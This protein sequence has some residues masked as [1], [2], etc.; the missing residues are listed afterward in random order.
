MRAS[1]L[2]RLP[3]LLFHELRTNRHAR[4]AV[5]TVAAVSALGVLSGAKAQ[6]SAASDFL[7]GTG[8]EQFVGLGLGAAI[9]VLGLVAASHGTMA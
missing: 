6:V 1:T 5:A 3:E 7:C 9:L 8:A 4:S 2:R